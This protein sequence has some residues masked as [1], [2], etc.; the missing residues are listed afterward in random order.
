M[1]AILG[2]AIA[3]ASAACQARSGGSPAIGG[4][5]PSQKLVAYRAKSGDVD[6]TGNY[7]VQLT[8]R[9]GGRE[10]ELWIWLKADG[11]GY[12]AAMQFQGQHAVDSL[13]VRVDG[14][15]VR[16]AVRA[17]DAWARRNA[18]VASGQTAS[19]RGA[20]DVTLTPPILDLVFAGR[21]F[22]G[23]RRGNEPEETLVGRR[24]ADRV[25]ER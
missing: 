18:R 11:T 5:A 16:L 9:R 23:T 10:A 15:R 1:R 6:P 2:L 19:E 22:A 14:K 21:E 20:P 24:I 13:S 3:L 8:G 17:D 4:P 12:G 25:P 7:H